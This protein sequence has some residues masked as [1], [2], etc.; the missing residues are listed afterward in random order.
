MPP[1]WRHS[2]RSPHLHGRRYLYLCDSRL[3]RYRDVPKGYPGH[4]RVGTTAGLGAIF[5][6]I[7]ESL[8]RLHMAL[9]RPLCSGSTESPM[10][11]R[12]RRSSVGLRGSS[13][14]LRGPSIG[15]RGPSVGLGGPSVGLSGPSVGLRG[16]YVALRGPSVGLRG[17]SVGLR[18]PSVGMRGP[19]VG[20]RGPSVVLRGPSSA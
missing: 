9:C 17:P 5:T 8:G 10:T 6:F 7:Y 3:S 15:L 13:V 1:M 2:Y 18:G 12:Q 14:D 11:Q 19:S 20:L 16:P 4:L